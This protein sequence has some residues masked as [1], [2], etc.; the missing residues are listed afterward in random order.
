MIG[1]KTSGITEKT[2]R[3]TIE[4]AQFDPVVVRK[5][6]MRLG[7]RTDAQTRYEKHIFP[8]ATM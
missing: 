3:V 5:T 7:L 1:G 6:A 4:I 8:H 2:K